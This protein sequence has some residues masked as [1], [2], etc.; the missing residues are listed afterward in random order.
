MG[1]ETKEFWGGG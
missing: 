1:R